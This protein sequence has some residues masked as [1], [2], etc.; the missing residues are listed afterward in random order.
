MCYNCSCHQIALNLIYDKNFICCN[1]KADLGAARS[2]HQEDLAGVPNSASDKQKKRN[3]LAEHK[4]HP[5][6]KFKE[7]MSR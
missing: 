6:I 2:W 4:Y 5:D 7:H 1:A 3:R